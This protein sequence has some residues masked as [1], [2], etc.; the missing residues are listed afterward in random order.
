MTQMALQMALLSSRIPTRNMVLS[1]AL[2]FRVSLFLLLAAFVLLVTLQNSSSGEAQ[3]IAAPQTVSVPA[4]S[5]IIGSNRTEREAAYQLDEDAYGH[6]V[7]RRNRWYESEPDRQSVDLPAF[8]IMKNLVT[9]ADFARFVAETGH[10]VP[11]V[12]PQTWSG[13]R[14]IHPF[15]RTRRHAWLGGTFPEGREDHPVVLV[16]HADARA[17]AAW[18]SERTGTEWRLPHELEWQ[19]AARGLDGLHFPWGDEYDANLLNSHDAGPFDTLPV[20]QFPEG[21]SPFGMLDAA[22]QVFEWTANPAGN[23]RWIVKGGS[24]D[25]RG[26]GVCRPAARHSRPEEIKHILVGFRLVRGTSR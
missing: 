21:A 13:Y 14:L 12:D 19:K 7:T 3:L 2:I 16:S 18:L 26:C 20:G 8:E 1:S 5:F 11:D 23:G 17:Y 22:G 6:N 25:D 4:G 15:Q 24:W 10:R 9:N